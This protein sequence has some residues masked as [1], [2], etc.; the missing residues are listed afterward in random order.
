MDTSDT[1]YYIP[2]RRYGGWL[3]NNDNLIPYTERGS[4]AIAGLLVAAYGALIKTA[5]HVSYKRLCNVLATSM[6]ESL[7]PINSH[8]LQL[9]PT[10]ARK[11]IVCLS[12]EFLSTCRQWFIYIQLHYTYLMSYDTF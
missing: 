11:S 4:P 8:P 10:D 7:Q 1:A 2:I 9:Y 12:T 5:S 6:P 3:G